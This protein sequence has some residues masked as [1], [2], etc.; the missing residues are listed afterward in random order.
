MLKYV[1]IAILV[2]LVSLYTW[3]TINTF[4]INNYISD[5]V[6]YPP[7]AL[8]ILKL[9]FGVNIPMS[10]DYPTN[11][12]IQYYI[13]PEH[14][15]LAK[16]II[17]LSILF[18][19]YNPI[20]WRIPG[21]ILGS[22]SLII[23]FLIGLEFF[24]DPKVK[25]LAGLISA[26]VVALDPNFWVM[27]G[28]AMLDGYAGFFSLL[29][30]YFLL[31]GRKKLAS[32]GLGLA[33]SIKESLYMLIFP[34]LYYLG[35]IERRIRF[36]VLYGIVIPLAT[37]L[38]IS[39]PII[40]YYGGINGWLQNSLLHSLSWAITSGHIA[41]S[42]TSQISEPWEWLFNINPFYL[43]YNF[44]ANT[45]PFI[46]IAWL[47]LTPFSFILRD[48]KLITTTTYAL[49]VWLGFIIVYFLGNNTLFSFY[50][51]DFSPVADVYVVVSAITLSEKLPELIKRMRGYK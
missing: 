35:E 45:N 29:S 40:I 12:G 4:T 38:I 23:A 27:H 47:C 41:P 3:F 16:Y 34:Y 46:L 9:I 2:I 25:Y 8:N 28:I 48:P 42:A 6:W 11:P 32:I 13:N 10:I 39:L 31:S 22:L 30:L 21:W 17:A 51:S 36:R 24:K 49:S 1:I 19:G 7:S 50:V 44:Y 18:L 37:Y 20:A 5:E 15:P 43:G 26:L 33:A 14:P